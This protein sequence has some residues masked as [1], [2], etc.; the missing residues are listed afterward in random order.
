MHR[1]DITRIVLKNFKGFSHFDLKFDSHKAIILGGKNGFG[2]TTIFD[3]IELIFTGRIARYVYYTEEMHDNRVS[4]NDN[5]LPLV[6][7]KDETEVLIE[8]YISSEDSNFILCRR[9]EVSK[10]TNP[11]SFEP[12]SELLFKEEG[13]VDYHVINDSELNRFELK[14]FFTTYNFINYLE[15]EEATSLLKV[16]EGKRSDNMKFL[17]NTSAFD[18]KIDNVKKVEGLF[19]DKKIK[20]NSEYDQKKRSIEIL[21]KTHSQSQT[22]EIV[23]YSPLMSG[24]SFEWDKK[25]PNLNS[26]EF[27]GL[28]QE[29]GI[30]DQ[31][32]Y[33]IEHKK[34]FY[35][36]VKNKQIEDILEPKVLGDLSYFI[37]YKDL[38]LEIE[39][40]RQY[41]NGFKKRFDLLDF[42]E[43]K[44]FDLKLPGKL[45]EVISVEIIQKIKQKTVTVKGLYQSA[46]RLDKAFNKLFIKRNELANYLQESNSSLNL[47]SCPLCGQ[48]Y[49]N[50]GKLLENIVHFESVLQDNTRDIKK[51]SSNLF[52]ELRDFIQDN[53]I[54]V[55]EDYFNQQ[56]ITNEVYKRYSILSIE[57]LRIKENLLYDKFNIDLIRDNT[58]EEIA[59]EIKDSLL[60]LWR[61]IDD[62]I[63]IESLKQIYLSYI[64]YFNKGK[65]TKEA[66][67]S[68][69]FYL[70]NIWNRIQSKLLTDAKA[71]QSKICL[72]I[73]KSNDYE[74]SLKK[75]KKQF[76]DKKN[77]YLSKVIGD[78]EI[79]FYIYSGRIMQDNNFG[80]GLFI[81]NLSKNKKNLKIQFVSNTSNQVDVLYRMSSGQLV[82]VVIS[83]LLAINRL[84][85]NKLYLAIDDPIQT[86]DDINMWGLLETLRH[87][88]S[89]YFFIFSTH[90]KAYGSLLRYK[91]KKWGIHAK[92]Y[93]LLEEKKLME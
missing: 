18:T 63:S 89:N 87:E 6:C 28:L 12:F 2:K 30:L 49:I 81:Q 35:Q 34:D 50:S 93:D 25:K 38:K 26:E 90:E 7:D 47:D 60:P 88:F 74:K 61:K 79:L 24:V 62:C 53:V 68:K 83:Y 13:D 69:R 59:E 9:A 52:S 39:L 14:D 27:N 45:N 55:I 65:L 33:F 85:S 19:K 57:D 56:G 8:L 86:I 44:D 80:R 54:E 91:L 16:K 43:L 58:V 41:V 66:I 3:A 17:F 22:L 77:N 42:D 82:S 70:I 40:Y 64:K 75:L 10:L 15:Q 84:Y 76:E 92:Y 5:E 31:I 73:K 48:K 29:R 46:E 72:K 23:D 32:D 1:L 78:I 20:L 21:E 37:Y 4:L 51:E 36:S 11:V 71:E 67:K